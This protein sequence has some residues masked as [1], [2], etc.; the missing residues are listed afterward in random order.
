MY[1]VGAIWGLYSLLPYSSKY[2]VNQLCVLRTGWVFS[3]A[4]GYQPPELKPN[5]EP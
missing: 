4:T 3:K 1:D 2:R 5:P